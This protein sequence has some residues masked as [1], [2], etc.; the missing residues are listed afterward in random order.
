MKENAKVKV[1]IKD[2]KFEISGSEEFVGNQI[3]KIKEI[4]N[5]VK[6]P[7]VSGEKEKI[8]KD[9]IIKNGDKTSD[10]KSEGVAPEHS[11]I[12]VVDEDKVKIIFE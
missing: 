4:F 7:E 9:K 8:K 6:I 12:F 2:G 3:D 5:T 10:L 1:S 11:D